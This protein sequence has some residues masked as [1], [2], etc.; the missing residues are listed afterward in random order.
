MFVRLFAALAAALSLFAFAAPAGAAAPTPEQA[1]RIQQMQ[2][3][4][5]SLH[6]RTGTVVL[7]EAEVTLNLGE[8]YYLLSGAEARRVPSRTRAWLRSRPRRRRPSRTKNPRRPEPAG[9]RG[10]S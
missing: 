2:A 3:L 7:P 8:G 4:M 6:P 9:R 1:A 10:P 5:D